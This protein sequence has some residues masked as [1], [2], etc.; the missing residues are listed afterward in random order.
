MSLSHKIPPVFLQK[1][2]QLIAISQEKNQ[3]W[4]CRSPNQAHT[5]P[6]I[7]C[8]SH[9]IFGFLRRSQI[10]IFSGLLNFFSLDL[11]GGYVIQK[12]LNAYRFVLNKRFC[13]LLSRLATNQVQYDIRHNLSICLLKNEVY[14]SGVGCRLIAVFQ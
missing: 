9:F 3:K 14:I 4:I 7:L 6:M 11:L 13:Y 2:R 8:V 10:Y 5:A 12:G 1:C